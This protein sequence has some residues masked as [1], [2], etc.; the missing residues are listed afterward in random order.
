MLRA[1]PHWIACWVLALVLAPGRGS[2]QVLTIDNSLDINSLVALLMAS[3]AQPITNAVYVGQPGSVGHFAQG[4][5]GIL[6]S[7]GVI[8][9]TGLAVEA[10]GPNDPLTEA[11][12]GMAGPG[13]ADLDALT[14]GPTFDAAVLEFDFVAQSDRMSFEFVFAS[15]E[16]PEFVGLFNDV[17]AFFV[18]GQDPAGGLYLSRNIALLPNSAIPITINNVNDTTNSEFYFDNTG[19]A[20]T[21]FDGLTTLIRVELATVPN[22]SY[23]LK[24][25]IADFMDDDLDSAVF[26][27]AGSFSTGL[28]ILAEDVCLGSPAQ[29]L[30][31][32]QS[33]VASL[34]WYFGDGQTSSLGSPTHRYWAPGTYAVRLEIT[35]NDGR[36]QA[37]TRAISVMDKPAGLLIEHE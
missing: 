34:L 33:E 28:S 5:A 15:E 29:F 4:Q 37:A 16:Y 14:G 12:E 27:K 22:T 6:P 17:F 3:D 18:T 31:S 13:D 1:R 26:L 32:P 7:E 2:S 8:L 35:F 30:F 10:I 19:G 23:H 24:I 36:T 21:A 11:D 25:A 9:S 20:N